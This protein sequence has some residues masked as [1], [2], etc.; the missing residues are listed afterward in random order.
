MLIYNF[1]TGKKYNKAI[2]KQLEKIISDNGYKSGLF[3]TGH[4][5][6]S[7]TGFIMKKGSK[8]HTI[9]IKLD[10]TPT[11]FKIFNL[12]QCVF[13]DEIKR[14]KKSVT[15]STEAG[16]NAP[17]NA[18]SEELKELEKTLQALNI[19]NPSDR[20]V[21]VLIDKKPSYVTFSYAEYQ[22]RKQ[23][24]EQKKLEKLQAE[25]LQ[26]EKDNANSYKGIAIHQLQENFKDNNVLY[27][28]IEEL[29][30]DGCEV[31]S[32]IANGANIVSFEANTYA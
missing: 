5:I 20:K 15:Y 7:N 10:N 29:L 13:K 26:A 25:K 4:Q 21:D 12:D 18:T 11:T 9:R 3:A 22:K 28:S 27:K 8:A 1:T 23:E 24:R 17:L 14:T 19:K 32:V 30:I 2:T 31:R 16:I 6:V